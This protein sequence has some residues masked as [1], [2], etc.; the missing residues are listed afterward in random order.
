MLHCII[1]FVIF[2]T[3]W[4][5]GETNSHGVPAI[6]MH[7]F[8]KYIISGFHNLVKVVSWATPWNHRL[9]TVQTKAVSSQQFRLTPRTEHQ[10]VPFCDYSVVRAKY[11]L[12]ILLHFIPQLTPFILT[13]FRYKIHLHNLSIDTAI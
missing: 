2:C 6:Y 1:Y 3:N 5:S 7:C 11:R 8:S 13:K 9:R 12:N 10:C 4:A